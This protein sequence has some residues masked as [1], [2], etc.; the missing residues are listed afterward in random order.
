ME[1][2]WELAGI[3]AD[4][5]MSGTQTERRPKFLLM[6]KD[7]EDGLIDLILCKSISRFSRNTLDAVSYIRKLKD[8]GVRIIFE[9]EASTPEMKFQRC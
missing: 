7:C 8:M 2:D 4:H 9:K 6:V 5:G 1:P 3:Y